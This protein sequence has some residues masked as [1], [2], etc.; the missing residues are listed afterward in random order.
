MSRWQ[1]Y[2]FPDCH[3]VPTHKAITGLYLALNERLEAWGLEPL[4]LPLP[5]SSSLEALRRLREKIG[6]LIWDGD[7][8]PYPGS[9]SHPSSRSFFFSRMSPD[10]D[11]FHPERVYYY[12]RRTS[13]WLHASADVCNRLY[14]V[15]N[16]LNYRVVRISREVK[17]SRKSA[18]SGYPSS[19]PFADAYQNLGTK[20]WNRISYTYKKSTDF[21]LG[22]VF[23]LLTSSEAGCG[24]I[25][26]PTI[27]VN[28]DDIVE[29][30]GE[31]FRCKFR[32]DELQVYNDYDRKIALAHFN[33]FGLRYKAEHEYVTRFVEGE[34][35]PF[36]D[37]DPGELDPGYINEIQA[38]MLEQRKEHATVGMQV[39]TRL[40]IYGD[41]SP[42]LD[43]YDPPEG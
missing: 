17:R 11:D 23:T 3:L 33:S 1:D 38:A 15:I 35:R 4:E 20:P 19:A 7:S 12:L 8:F 40:E 2:G 42:C 41:I 27:E 26:E 6:S 34:A 16:N 30:N 22:Y 21:S 36:S 37:A 13:L 43:F 9:S 24:A 31:I 28:N 32:V 25:K 39:G 18:S 29:G 5:L 14:I 10:S